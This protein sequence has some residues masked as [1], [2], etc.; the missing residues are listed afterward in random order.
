MM[1]HFLHP[2]SGECCKSELDLF[3][4]PPTQTSIE[5][6]NFVS[7]NP[8]SAIS[9]NDTPLEFVV[10]GTGEF[11]Y[12]PSNFFLYMKLSIER[13][14]GTPF[15]NDYI[16][17]PEKN[18]AS[19]LFNQAE[20]YLNQ[21]S[22]SSGSNHHHYRSYIE[23]LLNYSN[24]AKKTHLTTTGFYTNELKSDYI[25]KFKNSKKK[26]FDCFSR[27]HSDL[28]MQ[29]KLLLNGVDI[30]IK[31]SRSPHT[32][33]LNIADDVEEPNISIVHKIVD[34]YL[35]IRRVKLT[36]N[37]QLE[38]EKRLISSN[39]IYPIRKIETKLYTISSGL[40]SKSIDNI[41]IGNLPSKVIVGMLDH[42]AV[43]GDY[44]QSCFDFKN[45]NLRLLTLFYNGRAVGKPFE[46]EYTTGNETSLC[47]IPYHCLFSATG[48]YNELGNGITF[49]DFEKNCNLYA[50]DTSQ[51]LCFDS[52]NHLN[53][54]K[55]GNLS[56]NIEF[57]KA[58]LKPISLLVYLEYSSFIEIDK[59]RNII[60]RF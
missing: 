11:F 24:E 25:K 35:Y 19:T 3:T 6:S 50:F 53:P 51:D 58:L 54:V 30:K 9:S 7:I 42:S 49:D 29:P 48:N 57:A 17:Y 8:V 55:Q 23:T 22:V 15:E 5:D 2:S 1:Q 59:N 31:L 26:T 44:K 41:V 21:V 40:S 27:I 46:T 37:K 33:C 36:A 45:N 52:P 12:D 39:A 60:A 20:V 18:I 56:L 10:P 14:D 28:F 16:V 13:S 38:I 34:A 47:S 4:I 32:V 43:N